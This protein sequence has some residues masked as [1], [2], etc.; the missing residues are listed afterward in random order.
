MRE[1]LILFDRGT[2]TGNTR[3]VRHRKIITIVNSNTTDDINLAAGMQRE[4]AVFPLEKFDIGKRS[5]SIEHL[6]LVR[7][8]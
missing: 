1:V 8:A 3:R 7:F 4:R 5:N 6:L 2:D